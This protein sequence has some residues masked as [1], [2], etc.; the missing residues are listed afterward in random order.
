M[1]YLDSHS[2]KRTAFPLGASRWWAMLTVSGCAPSQLV[3]QS[4][5]ILRRHETLSRGRES[6]ARWVVLFTQTRKR[7][8]SRST[9][10][11]NVIYVAMTHVCVLID[12]T[13]LIS[14]M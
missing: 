5:E 12:E 6:G 11:F 9:Q 2:G 3:G 1:P 8:E 7:S 13:A 10:F 4:S 14:S